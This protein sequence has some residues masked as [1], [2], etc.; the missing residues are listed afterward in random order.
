MGLTKG[1]VVANQDVGVFVHGALRGHQAH[2]VPLVHRV[3]GPLV[4]ARVAAEGGHLDDLA[5]REQHVGQAEAATDYA[6]VAEQ[7][8]HFVRTRAGGHV[9]VLG[10]L[11]QQEITHAPADQIGRMPIPRQTLDDLGR[12]GVDALLGNNAG[13]AH[14]FGHAALRTMAETLASKW[15][16]ARVW[17]RAKL[18]R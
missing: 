9:E 18:S 17:A 3:D 10:L 6:A 8:A 14:G 5:P 11:A 12:V 7:S 16:R 13:V 4:L 15:R 1:V 2:A